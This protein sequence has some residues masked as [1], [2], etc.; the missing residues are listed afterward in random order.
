MKLNIILR[1]WFNV[2]VHSYMHRPSYLSRV[3]VR[4][5]ASVYC[6]LLNPA[7]TISFGYQGYVNHRQ[8]P[9]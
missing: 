1:Q 4:V 6:G 2:F 3:M 9:L 7:G 8:P 5:N